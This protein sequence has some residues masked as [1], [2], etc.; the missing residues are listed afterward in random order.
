METVCPL[1]NGLQIVTISCPLCGAVMQDGGT[2][3]SFSGPYAPYTDNEEEAGTAY[4]IHLLFCP[5][6]H[7]D[8]RQA[9]KMVII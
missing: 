2:I 9:C 8:S 4:C 3:E 1:C 6:C 5:S 7:Y